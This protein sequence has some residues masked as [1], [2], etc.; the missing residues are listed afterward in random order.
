[1]IHLA[2]PP[3][4]ERR[5]DIRCS[6]ITSCANASARPSF[7][8][9][10]D[11]GARALSL[12]GQRPRA[13]ERRRAGDVVG[14]RR[15]RRRRASAEPSFEARREPV[16]PITE[17]REQVADELYTALV[18]AAI[19]S[20]SISTRCS[21]SATL[22]DT[23]CGSWCAAGSDD[24]WQLPSLLRLFGM[25]SGL[26]AIL[27]FLAAHDC[28]VDFRA[29]RQGTAEPQRPPRL[30][31]RPCPQRRRCQRSRNHSPQQAKSTFRMSLSLVLLSAA[32]MP[33]DHGPDA[34][35]GRIC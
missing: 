28:D 9:G 22:R 14:E 18:T 20:G 6:S 11:G 32:A 5:D 12:A 19:R 13:P 26:Q 21:W 34:I 27:N 7:S 8:D 15:A 10:R 25:A 24:P 1:M 3:L 4:R 23:T 16:R 31:L 29:F 2:V 35:S 17:R 30:I 33:S